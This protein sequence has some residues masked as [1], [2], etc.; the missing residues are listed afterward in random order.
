MVYF[1]L[2]IESKAEMRAVLVC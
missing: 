2:V 1:T